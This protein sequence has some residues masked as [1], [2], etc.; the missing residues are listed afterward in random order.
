M[1]KN[2]FL[3]CPILLGS[4]GIALVKTTFDAPVVK[5]LQETERSAVI[6]CAPGTDDRMYADESGKFITLLPGWGTHAYPITTNSDSAQIYFNQGLSMY[7]SYHMKEAVASFKEAA[8]FDSTCAMAYWG[9]AL[10]MG[11]TYNFG[12]TYKMSSGVPA[13]IGLMNRNK[14][15]ASAKE[16]ALINAMNTRYNL[17]DTADKQRNVLNSNYVDALK[18]LVAKYPDDLDVKAL[19]TDAVMLVH[20]WSFWN[21]NGTPKPWTP[22]LVQYCEDILKKDPHHPAGLH[23]YIH[24]TEA[25]RKPDVALASADSLIKLFPGIAHMVHMSSHEYE[26]IG[27]YAKGVQANE[28]ADKSLGQYASLAKGLNLSAHVPHY[29]AVDA[30]CAL[31]GAM[32]KKALQKTTTL[33]SS[34]NPTYENTYSQYQY[35]YPLLAMVRMGKWQEILQDTTSIHTEWT[36][37]GILHDFAKGMAYAKSGD[38]TQAEKHLSQLREKQKDSILRIRFAPHMSSPYECSIVAENI[39]LANTTFYQKKHNE[40]FTA[41]NK[42]IRAEDSL[43]YAEPSLWMMPARQYKGAFLL[44]LNKP[45]EAEKVYREDLVWNPG[46]GWSLVGLYQALKKQGKTQELKKIKELYSN[47]FSEADSFPM[48]SAY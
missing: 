41:I 43:I 13:V 8:K 28:E 48:V 11:P 32:Y 4:I 46:N 23:Y 44:T 12:Y 2:L 29:Y 1:K 17:T 40:T 14:E 18:P 25:S 26:R 42:A 3:F 21:N 47:S 9:Q 37:A 34:V 36:Y 19:Y 35:M 16:Q 33:Q 24:I 38:Y 22:E 20:P 39:L 31:S 5:P 10:A 15:Q 27:Y 6:S 45:K 30:Y 7:Y